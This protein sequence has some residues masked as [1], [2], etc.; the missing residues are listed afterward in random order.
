MATQSTHGQ[1]QKDN[2]RLPIAAKLIFVFPFVRYRE[3]WETDIFPSNI[4]YREARINSP[5]VI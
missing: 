3:N 5:V 4:L 2:M 1:L